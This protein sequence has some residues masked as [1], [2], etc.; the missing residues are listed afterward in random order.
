MN[1]NSAGAGVQ[2]T[3][4]PTAEEVKARLL[5][6]LEECDLW[7]M[8]RRVLQR[9][10]AEHFGI[11]KRQ[12]S[13]FKPMIKETIRDFCVGKLHD[14]ESGAGA[15]GG[16]DEVES[17]YNGSGE[18]GNG[19]TGTES[20][21]VMDYVDEEVMEESLEEDD[22]VS[23][24]DTRSD[25]DYEAEEMDEEDSDEEV[26]REVPVQR[27]LRRSLRRPKPSEDEV[28]PH[29]KRHRRVYLNAFE[30]GMILAEELSE[31]MGELVQ[32]RTNCM[33][34]VHA[35][36]KEHDLR[37][38]NDR[39]V[40]ICDDTLRK[41]FKVDQ[42]SNMGLTKLLTDLLYKP[43]EVGD[44]RY[45]ELLKECDEKELASKL[46]RI[47]KDKRLGRRRRRYSRRADRDKSDTE[48]K[49]PRKKPIGIHA[50]RRLAPALAE[51]C[52][53]TVMSRQDAVRKIWEYIRENNLKVKAGIKLDD[54]LK[55]VFGNKEM[56]SN[57]EIFKRLDTNFVKSWFLGYV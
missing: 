27:E 20:S 32:S 54:K 17:S 13:A 42:F 4:E 10:L 28:N 14:G 11:R 37:D 26:S 22:Y 35:Y 53:A 34:R 25:K 19:A 5:D 15:A 6:M 36:V 8:T 2:R 24:D 9:D 3:S 46:Q 16:G 43:E 57:L 39:Q 51:V 18:F 45:D 49:R 29:D 41:L 44:N 12:L 52:G 38:R 21:T 31:F 47:E 1:N 7:Q 23:P 56:I 40:V 33:K 48:R 55:A 30:R 50:H